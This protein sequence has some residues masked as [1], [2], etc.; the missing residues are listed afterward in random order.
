M[1]WV[2]SS[3]R[4]GETSCSEARNTSASYVRQ[5]GNSVQLLLLLL[6]CLKCSKGRILCNKGRILRSKGRIL[7]H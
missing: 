5:T 7:C 3:E 2:E 4:T 6:L 1:G